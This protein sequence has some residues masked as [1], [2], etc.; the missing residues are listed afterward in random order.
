M[1]DVKFANNSE[2]G[3]YLKTDAVKLETTPS[4][5]WVLDGCTPLFSIATN[6]NA[7]ALV[8]D[9]EDNRVFVFLPTKYGS[10][11]VVRLSNCVWVGDN[12]RERQCLSKKIFLS[13]SLYEDKDNWGRSL[14]GETPLGS[15]FVGVEYSNDLL[16]ELLQTHTDV[17][18]RGD[19]HL[20]SFLDKGYY[21]TTE[22]CSVVDEFSMAETRILECFMERLS[23]TESAFDNEIVVSGKSFEE[24]L[25]TEGMYE[26][27]SLFKGRRIINLDMLLDI[28]TPEISDGSVAFD[29]P[30]MICL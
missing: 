29:I 18:W 9:N 17:S 27:G 15:Y 6:P 19:L 2:D 16:K 14:I 7:T 5:Y 3:M 13:N 26:F 4:S 8:P 20:T 11:V 23:D 21:G 25:Q 1:R 22:G 24:M 30:R 28:V 10:L 12:S